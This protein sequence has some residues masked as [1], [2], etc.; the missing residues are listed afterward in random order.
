MSDWI[1]DTLRAYG[2]NIGLEDF[3]LNADGGIELELDSG[4]CLG[5]QRLRDAPEDGILVYWGRGLN[6]DPGAQLE[7][8]LGM[9]NGR[10]TLPWPTQAAIR[11]QMLIMTMR[12]PASSFE[13]P[14]LEEAVN[15]LEAM[16]AEAAQ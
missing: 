12:L 4:E 8:A 16:Q 10:R 3:A 11:N 6:F 2:A 14:A 1:A 7:R 5:I 13:L 15:Q 9:V